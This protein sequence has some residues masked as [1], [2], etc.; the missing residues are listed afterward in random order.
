[1]TSALPLA[2]VFGQY[3][4]PDS[5]S[6]KYSFKCSQYVVT[7]SED[8]TYEVKTNIVSGRNKTV[9]ALYDIIAMPYPLGVETVKVKNGS[10]G[11]T[12]YFNNIVS[13][14]A[15][16]SLATALVPD[17]GIYDIQLLPYCPMQDICN[18]FGDGFTVDP[19]KVGT[20]Y[21]WI[22][23]SSNSDAKIGIVLYAS[24][25]QFT[26]DIDKSVYWNQYRVIKE[27]KTITSMPSPYN[28]ITNNIAYVLPTQQ[29]E[30]PH[31]TNQ[32]IIDTG[33]VNAIT[34]NKINKRTGEVVDTFNGSNFILT[35]HYGNYLISCSYGPTGART[36]P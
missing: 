33:D 31:T 16:T 8:H 19:N 26:F 35:P 29:Y 20:E 4:T 30:L 14:A 21:S 11:S 28:T 5:S 18:D 12:M 6:F 7:A 36:T 17:Q 3:T 24:K 15:M 22:T 2:A 34:F 1:M 13:M 25:C 9:D 10:S 23:D 32:S 27:F